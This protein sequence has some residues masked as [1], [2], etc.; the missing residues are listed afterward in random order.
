MGLE[1]FLLNFQKVILLNDVENFALSKVFQFCVDQKHIHVGKNLQWNPHEIHVEALW[2][3]CQTGGSHWHIPISSN[4]ERFLGLWSF[5]TL[6]SCGVVSI[7][8]HMLSSGHLWW[9]QHGILHA[10][11]ITLVATRIVKRMNF[12]HFDLLIIGSITR[13][14][15]CRE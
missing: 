4:N 13:S 2:W 8:H 15:S 3:S 12:V 5:R 14:G 1:T 11:T 9:F 7:E 10:L 6:Y